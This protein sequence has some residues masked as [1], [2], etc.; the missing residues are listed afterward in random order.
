MEQ[1][2]D[3]SLAHEMGYYSSSD[4]TLK[5]SDSA[6][7]PTSAA[8]RLKKKGKS[9][10]REK[11]IQSPPMTSFSAFHFD[12]KEDEN[13][14]SKQQSVKAVEVAQVV[15]QVAQVKAPP[16]PRRL[17]AP[18]RDFK[19]LQDTVNHM[20]KYHKL[21]VKRD[22][23]ARKHA[24]KVLQRYLRGFLTRTFLLSKSSLPSSSA[25]LKAW[26][27]RRRN[28]KAFKA[29]P[30]AP[31]FAPDLAPAPTPTPT[32]TPVPA[33][34]PTYASDTTKATILSK[35]KKH[36][37][38]YFDT[39]DDE[40]VSSP[41]NRS[42][43]QS[44]Y[45][46]S[47]NVQE[48]EGQNQDPAVVTLSQHEYNNLRAEVRAATEIAAVAKFHS[49]RLEKDLK[50]QQEKFASLEEVVHLL[51]KEVAHLGHEDKKTMSKALRKHRAGNI[52]MD[53]LDV[54]ATP[55]PTKS[56]ASPTTTPPPP[57]S[58]HPGPLPPTPKHLGKDGATCW[59]ETLDEKTG[60]IYYF[61][62]KTQETSWLPPENAKIIEMDALEVSG[63]LSPQFSP[64]MSPASD[65]ATSPSPSPSSSTTSNVTSLSSSTR[66]SPPKKR[67]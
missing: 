14:S 33:P 49:Q 2:I 40:E 64:P 17:F 46:D 11:I 7:S 34:A 45:Y 23:V 6:L 10:R 12:D 41:P 5:L 28:P 62:E 39:A 61:N 66:P 35:K 13:D 52:S 26:A 24:A 44:V 54:E 3:L 20:K 25:I 19:K 1:H 43:L 50:M 36:S 37:S 58:P 65:T 53:E 38:V 16:L 67:I 22:A 18:L 56:L 48:E 42:H 30:P 60:L 32:P 63:A 57:Q 4:I 51:L 29:P 59:H 55:I 31:V 27:Y 47:S 8:Q 9:G 21:W 15:S